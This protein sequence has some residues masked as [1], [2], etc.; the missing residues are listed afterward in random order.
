MS[1]TLL[2][3]AAILLSLTALFALLNHHYLRLPHTIGL[4]VIAMAASLAMIA[5]D[6][7]V[8][9]VR[10]GHA[11]TDAM[12]ELDFSDLLLEGILSFMLFAG[13]LHVD[14]SAIREQR[15]TIA[16]L[17]LVGTV[18]STFLIGT[19]LWLIFDFLELNMPYIW[20]LVFGAL[21]SPTDPVAVLG[22]FKKVRVPKPL[23]A[24]LAGESLFNDGVGIVVFAVLLAIAIGSGSE[25]LGPVGIME[26]FMVEALGGIGLGLVAG[27]AGYRA[28]RSVDD[29]SLE[30]LVTVALVVVTYTVALRFHMSGPLAMVAAGMFIGNRGVALAMSETTRDYLLKF[31]ELIDEILNSLLFVLIGFEVLIV[32]FTPTLIKETLIAIPVVLLGR[33][34]AVAVPLRALRFRR[35]FPKGSL[36]V[37]VWG[38][39]RGGIAVALALSIPDNP[40][41]VP[42]LTMTYG[43]V[44]FSIIVQG[45]TVGRLAQRAVTEASGQQPLAGGFDERRDSIPAG[46]PEA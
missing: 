39:L 35:V 42:I 2:D 45:L 3:A 18:A 14:L 6:L 19:A 8:P 5:V 34:V 11:V 22:I 16:A 46:R 9:G 37:L 31:W 20:F 25:P 28:L 27:Y 30:V 38:G 12:R 43:V 4:V 23:E 44:V 10:V 13:A 15:W 29:Y 21:I 1:V 26:I 7:V 17:A 36:P 33:A 24:T 41:R 32:S 40:Y